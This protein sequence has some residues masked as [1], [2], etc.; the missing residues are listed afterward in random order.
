MKRLLIV[1]DRYFVAEAMRGALA[2]GGFEV[3]G[4]T[5]LANQA[6]ALAA[7]ER[8]HL[9]LVDVLLGDEA[10]PLPEGVELAA[11]LRRDYGV[12]SL[13]VTGAEDLLDEEEGIGCVSKPCNHVQLIGAVAA[14]LAVIAGAAPPPGL[15]EGV[16]L[17]SGERRWTAAPATR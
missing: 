10:G 11:R 2:D 4:V 15:P 3:V 5:G 17:W 7:K 9:A 14:S 12:P 13:F 16:R 1:E 8:P 6:L